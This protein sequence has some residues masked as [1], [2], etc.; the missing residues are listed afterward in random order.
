MKMTKM[1][2]AAAAA[3]L[4]SSVAF[5]APPKFGAADAN[6]D[7]GVDAA[8]FKATKIDKDFGELDK[9][10]D[11]KLNADEYKVALEEDCA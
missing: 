8:E 4:A 10:G 11:G 9:D 1:T 2:L 7:G 3:L 6:A 5:A